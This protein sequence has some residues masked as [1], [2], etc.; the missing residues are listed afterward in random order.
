MSEE[1]TRGMIAEEKTVPIIDCP[2]CGKKD[3]P[4]S[5]S[6]PYVKGTLEVHVWSCPFCDSVLNFDRD[7][8][9]KKWISV[10]ELEKMG[11]K[12]DEY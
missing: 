8:E 3:V 9:P 2:Y 1:E 10:E 4:A 7:F 6:G 11:W 5:H 12:K